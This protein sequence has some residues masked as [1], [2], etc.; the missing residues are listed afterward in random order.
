MS[1]TE[2]QQ[3]TTRVWWQR[4][5]E[6]AALIAVP[7]T[8]AYAFG[9]VALWVQLS[10]V[11]Q[12]SDEWT[13]WY[14]ATIVY[15]P[16]AAG[17]GFGVLLRAFSFTLVVAGVSLLAW[18]LVTHRLWKR[19]LSDESLTRRI[20]LIVPLACLTVGGLLALLGFTGNTTPTVPSLYVIGAVILVY[21]VTLYLAM[22][23]S[24]GQRSIA[25]RIVKYYPK[26]IYSAMPLVGI[27]L[28]VVFV[29]FPG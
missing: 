17:L 21:L 24:P 4:F 5:V 25:K 20:I 7:P 9:V 2:A 1:E 13:L 15:K 16:V 22:A 14:A 11:Y 26:V 3:K 28:V 19:R 10:N 8:L 29:L 12:F 6:I 27:V 18:Y 23:A